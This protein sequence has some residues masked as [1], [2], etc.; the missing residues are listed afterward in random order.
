MVPYSKPKTPP[1]GHYLSPIVS[2]LVHGISPGLRD[3][4]ENGRGDLKLC[5]LWLLAHS[6]ALSLPC[7]F[8]CVNL[9]IYDSCRI[10]RRNEVFQYQSKS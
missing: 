9:E 2:C 8:L 5:S 1:G 7:K 6:S 10:L 4:H 3:D